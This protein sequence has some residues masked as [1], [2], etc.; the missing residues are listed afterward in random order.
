MSSPCKIEESKAHAMQNGSPRLP[1]DDSEDV[2]V[3]Q[4]PE[5]TSHYL[6]ISDIQ[7]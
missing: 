6:R 1:V 3:E 2:Q 7:G 4:D 5:G